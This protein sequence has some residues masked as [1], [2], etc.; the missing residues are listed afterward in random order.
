MRYVIVG[1]GA[2]GG[3]IGGRLA[4]HGHEVVLVARGRHA[5]V[6]A[7]DGLRLI[8]PD[9]EQTF[10]LPVVASAADLQLTPGDALVLST[11]TQDS[12]AVL[13]D[14]A[15]L[16]V[17]GTS[18]VA[19]EL[20]PVFCAQNGVEN[21]RLALRRFA[22]VY[23]VCVMLPASHLEPGVVQSQGSPYSGLLDLGRY[24]RGVDVTAAT[25]AADLASSG[26]VSE[27]LEE[28]MRWKYAKLLRNLG[29]AVDAL[30][31]SVNGT[32]Q[33]AGAEEILRQA[34]QEALD[35]FAAAAIDVVPSE[36]WT[37][38]RGGLVEIKPVAGQQRLGGSTW[39]SLARGAGSVEADYLN[40]EIVLLGRLHGIPTPVNAV[41]QEQVNTA[42]RQRVTPGSVS[43]DVLV[44][45]VRR[46]SESPSP[47]T[48]S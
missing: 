14:I 11:K 42:A 26:F 37:S 20:I 29:N 41:L 19:A 6:L 1:A 39:Q 30:C 25:V 47:S 40:G 34:R 2:V 23:G 22:H 48:T 27:A 15:G 7:S 24:P 9:G 33:T 21:E 44:E 17:S 8:A 13:R 28:V 16:P 12:A 38:H 32:N 3:T 46:R 10:R 5:E 36:E 18:R 35:C 31:S 4:Q 43:V 45:A